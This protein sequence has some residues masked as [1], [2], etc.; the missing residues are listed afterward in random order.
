MNQITADMYPRSAEQDTR[1]RLKSIEK[2]MDHLEEKLEN[3]TKLLKK[4]ERD[5]R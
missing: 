4:L 3:I 5:K 2:R 1:N